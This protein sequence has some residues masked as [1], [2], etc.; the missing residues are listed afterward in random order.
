MQMIEDSRSTETAAGTNVPSQTVEC[1]SSSAI[2]NPQRQAIHTRQEQSR[3]MRYWR[4]QQRS[5]NK[6]CKRET[7]KSSNNAQQVQPSD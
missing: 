3:S 1:L 6:H 5:D 2:N 4:A 7:D